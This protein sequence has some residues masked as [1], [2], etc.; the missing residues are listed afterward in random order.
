MINKIKKI[1]SIII[2]LS[3]FLMVTLSIVYFFTTTETEGLME[4][5]VF[6]CFK[7]FTIDSNVIAGISC[8]LLAIFQTISMI[9]NEYKIPRIFYLFKYISTTAVFV[10]FMT[11][12]LLLGPTMGYIF[13]FKGVNFI[14]H[15][16]SP[17]LCVFGLMFLE[18]EY[19]FTKKDNFLGLLPTLIYSCFYISFVLFLKIWKDFYG[20]TFGGKYFLIP[21]DF[22]VMYGLSYSISLILNKI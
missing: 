8:L 11:C 7:Y 15:L 3:V 19:S 10:T 17:L 9:K 13:I 5:T 18:K 12:V 20:F 14:L 21:L 22:I 2:N 16:A 1:I 6:K 4:S